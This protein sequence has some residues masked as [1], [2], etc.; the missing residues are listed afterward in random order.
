MKRKHIVPPVM[1][2]LTLFCVLLTGCSAL[3][4]LS[5]NPSKN[6]VSNDSKVPTV[7]EAPMLTPTASVQQPPQIEKNDPTQSD[8]L[9]GF[10]ELNKKSG[11][12]PKELIAY[13]KS[14]LG[15]MNE[16][17]AAI[18]ANDLAVQVVNYCASQNPIFDEL[19]GANDDLYNLQ[20]VSYSSA[21]RVENEPVAD[22]TAV[23][24]NELIDNGLMFYFA[25]GLVLD[26][27]AEAFLSLFD[28]G[29]KCEG[30]DFMR[31]FL[32]EQKQ[33]SML[34]GMLEITKEEMIARYDATVRFISDYPGSTLL[35]KIDEIRV[36]YLETVLISN[37][38]LFDYD[39]GKVR[40]EE[41]AVLNEYAAVC[42]GTQLE[43]ILLEYTA[44][45]E[46]EGWEKT[47][48][49]TAY[50]NEQGIKDVF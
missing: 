50:L 26:Y 4:V 15:S 9:K 27:D 36:S 30:T 14:N 46:K 29:I 1:L 33:P 6:P 5:R 22:E 31:I 48:A 38:G 37:W 24:L 47:E 25:E 18:A 49:V 41:H 13:L 2:S 28:V 20:D 3:N 44:L 45:L 35:G 8:A 7:S 42:K 11:T 23:Y 40:E 16:G 43:P 12:L 32:S 17:E 39:T 10:Q 34:E 19:Q 21:N